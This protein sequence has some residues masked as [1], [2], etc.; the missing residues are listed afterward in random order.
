[1]AD[2]VGI[3]RDP[4]TLKTLFDSRW[5][6]MGLIAKG[7][8]SNFT[9]VST[10]SSYRYLATATVENVRQPLVAIRPINCNAAY[11]S[12]G[13]TAEQASFQ[14]ERFKYGAGEHYVDYWI[15]DRIHPTQMN[16]NIGFWLR[17]PDTLDLTFSSEY[18]PM[19]F[20]P[21]GSAQPSGKIY[22][23]CSIP[24]MSWREDLE[25]EIDSWGNATGNI[26]TRTE[27]GGWEINGSQF[28]TNRVQGDYLVG[29]SFDSSFDPAD[30][31]WMLCDVT[32]H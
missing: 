31:Y 17:N 20:I 4:T 32:N 9:P 21:A 10:W 28:V 18:K 11:I 25:I 8:I 22:A 30:S 6:Q 3:I 5:P 12:M 14:F 27:V 7:R 24:G 19:R 15:Y 1:M 13:G 23:V 16:S 2:T 29:V 26:V